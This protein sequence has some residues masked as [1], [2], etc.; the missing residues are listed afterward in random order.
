MQVD[1]HGLLY[2]FVFLHVSSHSCPQPGL[3]FS[4]SAASSGLPIRVRQWASKGHFGVMVGRAC[5][6][7][8]RM[9]KICSVRLFGARSLASW[10]DERRRRRHM[11]S[12]DASSSDSS[13]QS[14]ASSSSQ[15][16]S[17][18]RRVK[19]RVNKNS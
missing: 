19:I 14:Q 6:H 2:I 1:G 13:L 15:S 12:R 17:G 9:W 18:R 8:V 7:V 4:S 3:F 16:G 11:T 10:T 5:L